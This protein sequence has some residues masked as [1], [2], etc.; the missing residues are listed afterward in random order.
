M[1][2]AIRATA[3]PLHIVVVHN[4]TQ[5][6]IT[7]TLSCITEGAGYPNTISVVD[8][9]GD[10]PSRAFLHS[11]YQAGIVQNLVTVLTPQPP[12]V[13]VLQALGTVEAPYAL[14][15]HSGML[16]RSS[17][18]LADML[19]SMLN[20]RVPALACF[21]TPKNGEADAAT[22]PLCETVVSPS[23]LSS[24]LCEAGAAVLATR[25]ALERLDIF[26]LRGFT[27]QPE[28]VPHSAE[29]AARETRRQA[30]QNLQ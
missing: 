29:I 1:K 7:A 27:E 13:P 6:E 12:V 30:V 26:S 22:A 24:M 20:S 16:F 8:I 21:A 25:H 9:S 15:M 23:V 5:L 11:A 10:A 4:A 28:Q 14:V 18:W 17:G 19:G 2:N 3:A